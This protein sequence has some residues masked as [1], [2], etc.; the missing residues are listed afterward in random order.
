MC[1]SQVGRA[2]GLQC[3]EAWLVG[4][5]SVW[6]PGSCSSCCLSVFIIHRNGLK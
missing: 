2:V 4:A 5:G 1:G 3:V 6:K